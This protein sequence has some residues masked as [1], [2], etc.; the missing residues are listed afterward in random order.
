MV[1]SMDIY[2]S[3]NINIRTVMKN[4]EM[5]NFIPDRLKKHEVEKVSYLL[6]HVPDQYNS[7]QM[8]DKAILETG[9]TL[10]SDC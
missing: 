9:R 4:L 2:K 8:C 7:Q 10:N 5:L 6:R 3:L 1:D